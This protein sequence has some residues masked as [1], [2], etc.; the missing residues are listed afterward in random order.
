MNQRI[1]DNYDAWEANDASQEAQLEGL[2]VCDDC[3]EPIQAEEFYTF[4][5]LCYCP[6]CVA[7]HHM[8]FAG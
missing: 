2:P 5:G 4:G 6:E 1:P 7:L 8:K 3:G